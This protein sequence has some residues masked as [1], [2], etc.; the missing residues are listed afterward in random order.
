MVNVYY[1]DDV[2]PQSDP[3]FIFFFATN[4]YYFV[5][6]YFANMSE[7]TGIFANTPVQVGIAMRSLP[8]YSAVFF[9]L[10]VT[11]KNY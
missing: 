2:T 1:S 4:I 11:R 6:F 10:R 3:K 5:F 9:V 8:Y 7:R